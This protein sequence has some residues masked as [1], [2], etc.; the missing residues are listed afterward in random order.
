MRRWRNHRRNDAAT[1]ST[2]PFS[3]SVKSLLH[4]AILLTNRA[5]NAANEH[6]EVPLS[7]FH[8]EL[9]TGKIDKLRSTL[10]DLYR[11]CGNVAVR[12]A[13]AELAD[14]L[15]PDFTGGRFA[16]RRKLEFLYEFLTAAKFAPPGRQYLQCVCRDNATKPP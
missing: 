2:P 3:Q 1:L 7:V 16:A 8:E 14:G 11:R 4:D 10:L 15:E 13:N 9:R 5:L 6:G 12:A